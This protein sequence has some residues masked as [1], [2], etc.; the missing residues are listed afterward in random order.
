[1]AAANEQRDPVFPLMLRLSG[2]RCLVVGG[3]RVAHGKTAQ[4]LRAGAHVTV[5]SPTWCR[6][7]QKLAV[8]RR[9]I[10]KT[11]R[12]TPGDL[13]GIFLIM[14]AT[15]DRALQRRLARLAHRRRILLNVADVPALCDFH[16][17]AVLRRGFLVLAVAT[18]GRLPILAR[19]MR[20][21]LEASLPVVD[22]SR[23]EQLVEAR[24][25]LRGRTPYGPERRRR[26][27]EHLLDSTGTDL[28]LN[29][30]EAAF[31]DHLADWKETVR[32]P[33]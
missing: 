17:P 14:A 4:L 31:R 9:L 5:V 19:I 1:M 15:S 20:D 22:E 30:P 32:W 24:L 8:S 11:D 13:E 3:G 28:L 10:L 26:A 25:W 2:R 23:L 29:G 21:L 7:F 33:S 12:F 18:G 27:M 6:A 16:M